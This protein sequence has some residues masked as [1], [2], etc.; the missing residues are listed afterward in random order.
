MAD[1]RTRISDG[2][3]AFFRENGYLVLRGVVAPAELRALQEATAALID[4]S[5]TLAKGDDPDVLFGRG[6]ASGE[7]VLRRIEYVIDK[8]DACQVLLA[9][10]FVLGTVEHL[11]GPDLLPTFDSM[12]VKMPGE[13]IA[14]PWHRDAPTT[15]VGDHPIFNVDFYLD[16]AD[17]ETAL[18]VIPGSNHWSDDEAGAEVARRNDPDRSP[19]RFVRDGAVQVFM[20]PGDVLLHD[21][22]VLH[23]SPPASGNDLRRVVYYEF[24]TAQVE[25][26]IGPHSLDYIPRKQRVLQACIARRAAAP[27]VDPA[28]AAYVYDPPPP[29]AIEALTA[30]NAPSTFRYAHEDHWRGTGR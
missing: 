30:D 2:D 27:Y 20:Q 3:A 25:S 5:A 7:H 21:I 26:T 13:G 1:T 6:H 17:E 10:P 9:H 4:E 24:R 23:G 11:M 18:W 19:D 22:L 8:L 16:A 14:V 29:F 12:V 28:E 15:D